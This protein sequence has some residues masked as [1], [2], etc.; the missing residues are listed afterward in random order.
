M[1]ECLCESF[2]CAL[3]VRLVTSV[4]QSIIS[5]P[6]LNDQQWAAGWCGG[7]VNRKGRGSALVM[8]GLC[9]WDL[10]GTF[11]LT[12]E[13]LIITPGV[14]CTGQRGCNFAFWDTPLPSN[15]TQLCSILILESPTNQTTSPTTKV[16]LEVFP[17]TFEILL[18][19]GGS[20]DSNRGIIV[21]LVMRPI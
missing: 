18:T 11:H 14:Y 3:L 5:E 20:H 16:R 13:S 19:W 6:G 15:K 17:S 1:F 12:R 21:K 8:A 10:A 4:V 7:G 9:K 2:L